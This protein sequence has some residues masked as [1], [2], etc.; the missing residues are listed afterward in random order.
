MSKEEILDKQVDKEELE[1]VSGGGKAVGEGGCTK[2]YYREPCDKTVEVNSDCWT[3]DYCEFT[4][5]KYT[6][7]GG[8]VA[9]YANGILFQTENSI[10]DK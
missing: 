5:T 7:P 10:Q 4:H 2:S 8:C 9:V 1:K 6:P 3:N